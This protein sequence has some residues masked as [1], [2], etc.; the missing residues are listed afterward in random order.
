MTNAMS[1][2][3]KTLWNGPVAMYFAFSM[4]D[5]RTIGLVLIT[6]DAWL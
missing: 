5:K 4:Y 1:A 3:E 6:G 2:E